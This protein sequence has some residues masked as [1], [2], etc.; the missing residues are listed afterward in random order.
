MIFSRAQLVS[1]PV[2]PHAYRDVTLCTVE[3]L[4]I[5]D[6]GLEPPRASGPQYLTDFT[7][8]LYFCGPA[9]TGRLARQEAGRHGPAGIARY[10]L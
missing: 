1:I 6:L 7:T 3:L 4:C 10:Y 2:V 9:G 8:D 5:A